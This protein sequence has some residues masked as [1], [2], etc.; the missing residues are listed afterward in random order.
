MKVRALVVAAVA[1]L[2]SLVVVPAASAGGSACYDVSVTVNGDSV[3]NEA[4]C[5][6]LP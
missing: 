2:S 5:H 6:E 4:A 1:A 3:V